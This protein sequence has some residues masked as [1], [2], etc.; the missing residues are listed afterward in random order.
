ML[1]KRNTMELD[2]V[3]KPNEVE[4]DYFHFPR[5]PSAR[6]FCIIP[7]GLVQSLVGFFFVSVTGFFLNHLVCLFLEW[8]NLKVVDPKSKLMPANLRPYIYF[9]LS[10]SLSLIQSLYT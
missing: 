3:E 9:S 2:L 5:L 1:W 10:H 6:L 8:I 4:I 7:A